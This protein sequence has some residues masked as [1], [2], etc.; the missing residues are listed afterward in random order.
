M[1]RKRSVGRRPDS[2]RTRSY[3]L[4]SHCGR[5]RS[6]F[7]KAAWT[8]EGMLPDV[9]EY[10]TKKLIAR[11]RAINIKFGKSIYA[12]GSGQEP[13][14]GQALLGLLLRGGQGDR[15]RL[16]QEPQIGDPRLPSEVAPHR[17]HESPGRFVQDRP[18]RRALLEM[19]P[20]SR[21]VP[22]GSQPERERSSP[23]AGQHRPSRD[24]A[25]GERQ[26]G[27]EV[28]EV[29]DVLAALRQVMARHV[30]ACFLKLRGDPPAGH[31]EH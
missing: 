13:A 7:G 22:G 20:P 9:E 23:G 25:A 5:V 12:R 29:E 1:S 27:R 21:G 24:L 19:K 6:A 10:N 4:V 11:S 28:P 18:E 16:S 8:N 17:L 15:D 2:V 31:A 30:D 26:P 14:Q 3:P